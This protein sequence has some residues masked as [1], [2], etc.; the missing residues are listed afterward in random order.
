M[1]AVDLVEGGDEDVATLRSHLPDTGL[2]IVN[3]CARSFDGLG[4]LRRLHEEAVTGR[5]LT[6]VIDDPLH[7]VEAGVRPSASWAYAGSSTTR[8]RRRRS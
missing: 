3:L 5:I 6:W 2:L 8:R 7:P 1:F 4:L